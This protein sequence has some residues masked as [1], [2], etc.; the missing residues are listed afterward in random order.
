ML[1][2]FLIY[3]LVIC[4]CV[5]VSYFADK[6][7]RKSFLWI[8]C[9]ALVSLTGFRCESVGIDTQNYIDIWY[10]ETDYTEKGEYLFAFLINWLRQF[11]YD[12]TWLF[13]SCSVIIFPLF[14]FRLWDFRSI[15]SLSVMVATLCF[16][17]LL[18]TMN[19]MRQYVAVAVIFY[20]SRYIPS[21][22]YLVFLFG[23][24]IAFLFH[25]SSALAV[26]FLGIDLIF[27]WKSFDIHR[28]VYVVLMVVAFALVIVRLF[29]YLF[30]KYS[31]YFEELEVDTGMFVVAK[32]LF[33][34]F[35]LI[36]GKP[37]KR[38]RD[39]PIVQNDVTNAVLLFLIG[40][41]FQSIGYF[42]PYMDRIGLSY[43]VFEIPFWGIVFKSKFS[44]NNMVY[45]FCYGVLV[46]GRF[47][48]IV[49]SGNYNYYLCF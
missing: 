33:V 2:S 43:V 20:F 35:F 23:V 21:G 28:K 44:L 41:F 31:Y 8:V 18:P 39:T 19:I 47:C 6:Y 24:F 5:I 37:F 29:V 15:A 9:L 11:T 7:E 10:E 34:C 27:K 42:F 12:P 17:H 40:L 3:I 48:L 1:Y 49:G 46:I 14:V 22:K 4:F 26:G 32:L 16:I 38:Y 30:S 25:R 13:V 45:V 36:I